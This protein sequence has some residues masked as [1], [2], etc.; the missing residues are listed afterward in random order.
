MTNSIDEDDEDDGWPSLATWAILPIDQV[1]RLEEQ[2]YGFAITP[3]PA[4]T[5][6]E[7]AERAAAKVVGTK[8]GARHKEQPEMSTDSPTDPLANL[9]HLSDVELREVADRLA[10]AAQEEARQQSAD[11]RPML[12]LSALAPDRLKQLAT[13]R[14]QA[15][16]DRLLDLW[17]LQA[18]R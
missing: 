9:A 13:C 5:P 4:S 8:R 16:V 17:G 14:A 3:L 15:E 18:P 7:R 11:K 1:R 6:R 12:N 2:F 10:R